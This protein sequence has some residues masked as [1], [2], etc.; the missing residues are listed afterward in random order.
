MKA[1]L[2]TLALLLPV[3]T[4]AAQTR[5]SSVSRPCAASQRDVQVN[6]AI[7]LGTGGYTYDRFVRDRSFCLVNE[8]TDPAFVPSA[9]T[10]ACFVGYRCKSKLWFDD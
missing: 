3:G 2:L 1:I 5:P 7:V 6:G 10:Q 4:A 9:D 8:V